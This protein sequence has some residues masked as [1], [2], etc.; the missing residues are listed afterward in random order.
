M[1]RSDMVT[2]LA[3][4]ID[5]CCLPGEWSYKYSREAAEELLTK[6]EEAGMLPPYSGFHEEVDIEDRWGRIMEP[7]GTFMRVLRNKWSP[8]DGEK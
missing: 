2:T 3:V 8:E 7:K 6:L 1:K 4:A 5:G